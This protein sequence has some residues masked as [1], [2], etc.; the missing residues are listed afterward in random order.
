MPVGSVSV[1]TEHGEITRN[2]EKPAAFPL[3]TTS[4]KSRQTGHSPH[5]TR[6]LPPLPHGASTAA[7]RHARPGATHH[8]R[9]VRAAR[10]R[11]TVFVGPRH[12]GRRRHGPLVRPLCADARVERAPVAGTGGGRRQR[13]VRARQPPDVRLAG[14]PV[15]LQVCQGRGREG[16]GCQSDGLSKPGHHS[17]T[18]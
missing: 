2:T 18:V 17:N 13:L 4:N 14:S 15:R 7:H 8:L 1:Q 12:H 3:L 9:T 6:P 10:R 16:G 5:P 11:R